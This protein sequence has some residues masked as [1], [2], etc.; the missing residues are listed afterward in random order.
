LRPE[1]HAGKA[2]NYDLGRPEYPEAFYAYVY[3]AFGLC[4]DAVIADIGAGPGKITRG[5]LER[6]NPVYAIEPDGDMLRI[7]QSR[8]ISFEKCTVLGNHVEETGIPTGC[9]DLIF[10]GNSYHWFDRARVIPEFR[11]ILKP[12]EGANVILAWLRGLPGKSDELFASLGRYRKPLDSRHDE[13]S[14]FREGAFRS[15]EFDF[16]VGQDW[17]MFLN[18]SLS[19][20]GSPNPGDDFFEEYC[21]ALRRHF[22]QCS[23]DGRLE[24][25]FQLSCMT[26]NVNDLI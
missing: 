19:Y 16:A 13:S 20:S 18:G 21:G 3:G 1:T 24:T 23:K 6:A 26:G 8:L 10:C 22:D 12:G 9:V 4:P 25:K 11:R 15:R 17:G 14:P 5:F 7:L 2:Q